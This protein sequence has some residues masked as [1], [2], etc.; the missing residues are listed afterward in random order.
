MEQGRR[1]FGGRPP[2]G[3]F[4]GFA[5]VVLVVGG[6]IALNN[7]LFNGMARDSAHFAV[8][9]AFQFVRFFTPLFLSH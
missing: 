1:G 6:G 2:K 7:S 3:L 5:G 4:S 8:L 9:F